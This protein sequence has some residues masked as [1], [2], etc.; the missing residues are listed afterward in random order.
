MKTKPE[1]KVALRLVTFTRDASF[2]LNGDELVVTHAPRAH[3][4]GDSIVEF[5]KSNVIHMG[6]TFFNKMYRSSTPRAVAAS[7][8]CS[9]RQTA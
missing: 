1:P 5:R 3:T 7:P 4:D 2:H 9:P 8:A 6:D